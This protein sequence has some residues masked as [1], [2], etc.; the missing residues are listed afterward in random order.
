MISSAGT[1]NTVNLVILATSDLHGNLWG[2]RY[3][4]GADTANDGMARVASYVQ[5]VRQSGAAVILID[6][7]DVFQGNILTDDVYNKRLDIVHPV[8]VAMNAMGYA[9]MTLGNHD[10]N[11][12][13][14]LIDKF[15]KELNCPVLA[16]NAWY[17]SG[18]R[19]AQPYS[20]IE[21]QGIKVAVI[22]LTNPNVPRWDGDKVSALRFEAM[23]ETARSL[24]AELKA[25]KKADIIV[26]SAHAG[27]V[28]E[29]DE[30]GGSDSAEH[31][32]RLVP[33]ADVLMVGHMH[34][35][36]K[37]RFGDTVIGGPRDRGREVVRFD[38]EVQL[39]GD[40]PRVVGR[41]VSIIDMGGW[42]PDPA[43]RS[44]VSEA[45]E[46]TL[47]FI[48]Q[49][50]RANSSGEGGRVAEAAADF[51]PRDEISGVPE[52]R[53]RPTAVITLI[54]KVLLQASGADVAATSLFSDKA[55][56][57]KGPL[58]YANV[59]SIYPFD[60]LLYVVTVTGKELKTYMEI[61]AAHYNQWK[62]GDLSVSFNPEVP[63]YLYDMF[64]GI[65]YRID[66]SQPSGKRIK[67][68]VYNGQP[69]ADNEPLQLAVNNYRYSSLLKASRLVRA[70]KHWESP[71]S[72]R[73]LIVD[74]IRERQ[75]IS[76]E[77]D[78]NWSIAG[79]NLSSPY[80][81]EAIRLVNE[82][83]LERPTHKSLNVKELQAG[84]WISLS[85]LNKPSDRRI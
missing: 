6:N 50:G 17:R 28:A 40:Q 18:E 32:A 43:I 27:M 25:G 53:L 75:T 59:F 44:I 38:L 12:G 23:P 5:E 19:F 45:H 35:T 85:P 26:I 31:I 71:Q 22:G 42:E 33:E 37:E 29:F 54:Q 64:A 79:I 70:T 66:L 80:R 52:G 47:R 10:F 3:E 36:V 83:K 46:A 51:Q 57:R 73:D 62:P 69:L 24:S 14:G 84:G 72:I 82:G 15:S 65:H 81:D 58:T 39:D 77:T 41:E 1:G 74:Y 30:E 7:G 9:A 55:D 2:Y 61:S 68:V 60:N 67:D 49:G 4:D 16:A 8:S 20:I 78:D 48:E 11:F 13:L 21:V 56:L 34:I 76:P 63:A